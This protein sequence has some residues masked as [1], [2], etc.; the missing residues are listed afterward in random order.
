MP[1]NNVIEFHR[2]GA[3]PYVKTSLRIGDYAA[4]IFCNSN[5]VSN[6]YSYV[7]TKLDS[8]EILNLGQADSLEQA[9]W[10]AEEVIRYIA[11]AA[12]KAS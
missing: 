3:S 5:A 11:S 9:Q 1:T 12:S 2:K 7:I 4:D 8:T 10:D 6:Q